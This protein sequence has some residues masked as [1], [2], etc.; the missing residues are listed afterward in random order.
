M[1][2]TY[3]SEQDALRDSVRRFVEREYGWED[4]L[5]MIRTPSGAEPRHWG[6]F[7]ELGWLGAGLSEDEG[8][9]GGGAIENALIAE[10]LGR[11]LVTEPF[12][13]H[14]IAMQL[15]AAIG[16]EPSADMLGEAITG[17]TRIVAALQEAAGRGDWRVVET[18][19]DAGRLTGTKTLV[20]GAMSADRLIVSTRDGDTLGLYLVECATEGVSRQAYRTL[21]NRRVADVTF[22]AAPATLLASGEAAQAAINRAIDH[23]LVALCGEALG[24]MDAALWK[25]RDYLKIRKQFGT[26]IGNFQTLQHRMADM[27][28]EVEMTRSILY[29]ALGAMDRE[30]AAARTAAVAAAKVQAS[31]GGVMVAGQAI[32]LHGGIGV[33]EELDI[34]HYYRRLYVI[35]RQFGDAE[36]HLT[37]FAEARDQAA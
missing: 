13:A 18:R 15:L 24:L 4:R 6:I 37:R 12:I 14:A 1:D 19:A 22:A 8:G 21:D 9:F 7:A 26:A 32:Q 10:E 30:D 31:T 16:D 25:T 17:E 33:T 29:A 20:E 23:G 3:T 34:S 2:F 11:G 28:I 35:A 27:L 36:L 5:R